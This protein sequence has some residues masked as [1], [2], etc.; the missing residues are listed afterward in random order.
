MGKKVYPDRKQGVSRDYPPEMLTKN[1]LK[2]SYSV[3]NPYMEETYIQD[4][5]TNF[6]KSLLQTKSTRNLSQAA[7]ELEKE[8]RFS[9]LI[10]SKSQAHLP[11]I[12]SQ[13]YSEKPQVNPDHTPKIRTF[14]NKS[15]IP[16]DFDR[17]YPFTF[18]RNCTGLKADD[19]L[20]FSDSGKLDPISKDNPTRRVE[21]GAQLRGFNNMNIFK[22][23]D[24]T[25]NKAE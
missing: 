2:S 1:E 9:S 6:N 3:T 23:E 22:A 11:A 15:E 5:I 21:V 10:G 4:S 17:K 7:K 13:R 25:L 16:K 12:S 18:V 14:L 8:K 19:P 24:L 20:K